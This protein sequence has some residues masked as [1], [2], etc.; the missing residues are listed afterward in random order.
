MSKVRFAPSFSAGQRINI[1]PDLIDV[2][3]QFP[4][5]SELSWP[6]TSTQEFYKTIHMRGYLHA[7]CI[8]GEAA[9][10]VRDV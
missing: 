6:A 8:N 1:T 3:D 2:D 10:F 5:S 4:L 7:I 9:L